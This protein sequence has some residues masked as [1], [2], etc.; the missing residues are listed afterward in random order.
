MDATTGASGNTALANG[1]TF[2]PPLNGTNG[3]DN[4]WEL[5]TPFASGGTV[6]ESGGEGAENAPEIR[7]RISGLTPGA[8]YRINAHFWDAVPAWRVRAGFT[9][10]SGANT[11]YASSSEA[12]GI[13]ATAAPAASTLAYATAPTLFVEGDRTMYAAALGTIQADASG[14]IDVYIDDLRP[15]LGANDRTWYDGVSYELSANPSAVTYVDATTTNTTRWDGQTFSPKPD[16]T[17]G[18]DNNWETRALGNNGTVFESNAEAAEDAPLLI[19]TISGLTPATSYIVYAYYWTTGDN[20]RLKASVNMADIRDNGT[21]T[22]LS[23]DYLPTFPLTHFAGTNNA[24]GTATVGTAASATTFVSTPLLTE[25]NRTLMQAAIGP[26]T[27]GSDG[28]LRVYI[29]DFA[30]ADQTR[31]TWYDGIGWKAAGTLVPTA[32]EDGDGLTNADEQTR[33]TNPYVADS[34]GDTYSDG[35]EVAAESNPLDVRSIPPLPGN[36]LAVVPD[37]AWTWFNDDRAIFHQ[38]SLFIGY[39]KKGG[40]YGITRY[41]PVAN[42][43]H[44]MIIS[45]TDSQQADD[46]NNPSIT[47]LPDGRLMVLYS[48]HLGGSRF[49]QRT[50][51]VP[52]PTTDTDWG[53]E[54]IHPLTD[55]NTYDNTYLLGGEGNR[56]YNFHRNIN[57]NPTI[58]VS[59]DLG[60]T[61]KPSVQFIDVGSGNVRP[62]PR[63]CSNGTD[64]ID[65]IYTDGHPR[66]VDN[67]VYHMFYRAGNFYKTDGTLIDSFANLPLDHE[68]GQRGS[69]IYPFSSAAWGPGQGPDDWIPN[70]RGW[71]WDVQYGADG[72]PVCVFQVQVGTDATWSTSRIFYYYARWTGTAWQRRFIARAGRGIYASE[73]DYGGGMCI[74]SENTNVVYISSNAADPFNLAEV[75]NVPLAANARFEIYRG[76]TTDGGLTFT[77]TPVTRDSPTDNLRP[78]VPEHHGY[79][80]ALLWLNGTYNSYTSFDIRVLAILY[81]NPRVRAFSFDPGSNGGSLTWSSSPGFRYRITGSADLSSFGSA[82]ATSVNSQGATTTRAFTFPV[83]LRNVPRAFYRVETE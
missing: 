74:D 82:A 20:W 9:S 28:K 58:T 78:I 65:L 81:N 61:W 72:N 59:D 42:L 40:Q 71:T 76:V 23:D 73:S 63:Y 80:R 32:D 27:A 37:G 14:V 83:P 6:L 2:S 4:Q 31:R 8:T 34:D 18:A 19:T 60:A 48:K 38:G 62:Y 70:A 69:V 1:S 17:T 46:H 29:D 44:H 67:S 68:G 3:Q 77:W 25:G 50:S 66:D 5:R 53:P 75:N 43:S 7:T 11:L 24:D 79:D 51:L 55:N 56:I 16:G 41:D 13:G 39:V 36:S 30:G 22:D 57:F 10:N 35:V 49:F 33:G 26:A 21:P 45:T 64:R 47:G 54:V 12:A 52:L 15:V